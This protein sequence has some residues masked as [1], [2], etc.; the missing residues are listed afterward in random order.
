[1]PTLYG[2][3][4]CD[5]VRKARRWLKENG[6][7]YRFHDYKKLGIDTQSLERWA[8]ELGWE[9]LLNRRGTSW[10]KL[11]ESERDGVN[12]ARAIQLMQAH[13]SL[14][15]RPL[16]ET[17]TGRVLGFSEAHYREHLLES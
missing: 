11:P 6:I 17:E 9:S 5:S 1:M 2:I 8:D 14:I 12:R 10:R 16:L 3:P 4:N 7:D 13:P 15:K